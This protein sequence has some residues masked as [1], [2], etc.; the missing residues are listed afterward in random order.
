M[1]LTKISH[2]QL[3]LTA[4]IELLSSQKVNQQSPNLN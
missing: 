1:H 4:Q 2:N 3:D